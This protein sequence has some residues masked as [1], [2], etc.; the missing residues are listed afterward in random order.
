MSELNLNNTCIVVVTN[1]VWIS[2]D[3]E[4]FGLVLRVG[5]AFNY[6][7]IKTLWVDGYLPHFMQEDFTLSYICQFNCQF[8]GVTI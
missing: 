7:T 4:S 1:L 2:P 3:N 8:S 6:K 5:P